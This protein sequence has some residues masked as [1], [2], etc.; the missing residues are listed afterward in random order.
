MSDYTE[1]IAKYL[2]NE[3]KPL[4]KVAWLLG[5][6]SRDDFDKK[7]DVDLVVV[8]NDESEIPK[9]NT[10]ILTLSQ[11]L[12]REVDV[13]SFSTEDVKKRVNLND[14]LLASLLEE[15][16]YLFGDEK[17]L[18][19][20]KE[21]IF[22]KEPTEE[23]IKYNLL[24]GIQILDMGIITFDNFRYYLRKVF[25]KI[26]PEPREFVEKVIN[27]KFDVKFTL[28]EEDSDL[29]TAK[30]YLLQTVRNCVFA[31]SYLLAADKIK[32]L[33]RTVSLKDI[34]GQTNTVEEK[35]FNELF[36][37]EK[38]CKKTMDPDSLL[39]EK[40]LIATAYVFKKKFGLS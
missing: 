19:E 1:Q 27:D 3:L 36:S 32:T 39:V 34:K 2:R 11:N 40:Y 10:K 31:V 8:T 5:S 20:T 4:T 37:Y 6:Y 13:T 26:P 38:Y 30:L 22:S 9:L 35:L 21:N 33:K 24:E 16:K 15:E 23:S 14:Y 25:R 12:K 28:G 17:F 18:R 7:S 29:N